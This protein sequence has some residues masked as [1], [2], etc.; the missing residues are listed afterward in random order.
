MGSDALGLAFAG[1][2]S[3]KPKTERRLRSTTPTA[4]PVVRKLQRD[5]TAPIGGT[6]SRRQDF[7]RTLPT[8]L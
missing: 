7:V 3:A 4:I 5:M 2:R 6:P 1:H 8:L